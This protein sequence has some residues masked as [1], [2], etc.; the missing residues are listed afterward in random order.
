MADKKITKIEYFGQIRDIVAASDIENKEDA[1]KFIDH[2]VEIIKGK[3]AKAKERAEKKVAEGDEMREAVYNLLTSEFQT[4]EDITAQLENLG[5]FDEVT[6]SKVT[7]RL[8]GLIKAGKAEKDMVKVEGS[9]RKITAY[10]LA[11]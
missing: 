1:L 6:K 11:E 10:K 5:Q 7:A 9:K 8:S 3:A 4:G 2:E